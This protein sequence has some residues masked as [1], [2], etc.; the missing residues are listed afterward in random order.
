[1][2]KLSILHRDFLNSKVKILAPRKALMLPES[3]TVEETVNFLKQHA[4]GGVLI[5]QAVGVEGIFTERDVLKFLATNLTPAALKEPVASLCTKNLV[6]LKPTA[7][8][9]RLIH[10]MATGGMRHI[11]II[12]SSSVAII[13]M[14]DV[15][16][17]IYERITSKIANLESVVIA[18]K[19]SVDGFFENNVITM[20]LEKGATAPPETSLQSC[21]DRMVAGKSGSIVII[22]SEMKVSGIF[23]ERDFVRKASLGEVSRTTE[24]SKLM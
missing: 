2:N 9:A 10:T 3:S 14:R 15:L 8:I 18:S 1:M 11:P 7:S 16:R 21:L 5:G 19:L 4:I 17:F 20:P 23:T 24:I 12:D 6:S 13:S 22:D